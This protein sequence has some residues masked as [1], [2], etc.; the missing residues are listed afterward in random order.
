LNLAGN[1]FTDVG[2]GQLVAAL[3]NF[4]ALEELSLYHN[5][6]IS[7]AGACALVN[8]LMPSTTGRRCRLRLLNLA[9]CNIKDGGCS[10]LSTALRVNDRLTELDL[11]CNQ[12]RNVTS[13]AE[14]LAINRTLHTLN[15]ALN[16]IKTQGKQM[17][18]AAVS[19]HMRSAIKRV[20]VSMQR[21]SIDN[22]KENAN[23]D[24]GD[25]VVEARSTRR[26]MLLQI[27]MKLEKGAVV[28][29][30]IARDD[31]ISCFVGLDE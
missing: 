14:A 28:P 2:T 31:V 15:L 5:P 1:D 17:L 30:S 6:M 22:I 26:S 13:L 3:Q 19:G 18:V 8:L 27:L 21:S 25:D 9:S 16:A 29:G 4:D 24:H 12:I 10:S 7:D 11:S 23:A 20:D